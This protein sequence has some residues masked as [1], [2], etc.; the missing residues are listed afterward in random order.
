MKTMHLDFIPAQ[1][2]RERLTA[3]KPGEPITYA[4]GLLAVAIEEAR[5]NGDPLG[6]EV[7][8]LKKA[9]W[10]AMEHG[11]AQLAQR[12]I[13]VMPK[14]PLVGKFEYL[15]IRRTSGNSR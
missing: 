1:E 7:Q 2:F 4:T 12:R 6:E 8:A 15:A 10:K 11:D 9:A 5:L 13:G 3:A 14:A